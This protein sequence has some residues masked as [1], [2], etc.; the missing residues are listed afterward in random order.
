MVTVPRNPL[1]KGQA[2]RRS[3][4]Y[5]SRPEQARGVARTQGANAC[6]RVACTVPPL[7]SA[8]AQ[9]RPPIMQ[10]ACPKSSERPH[11][12]VMGRRIRWIRVDHAQPCRN[13][14]ITAI[15]ERM[16]GNLSYPECTARAR[17]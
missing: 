9:G 16:C 6:G 3:I 7:V 12:L 11:T 15:P 4:A 2:E 8:R 14:S 10:T 17:P 5:S 1:S 13:R